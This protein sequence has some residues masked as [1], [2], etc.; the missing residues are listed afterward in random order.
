MG[1][2]A[3]LF[4]VKT[5]SSISNGTLRLRSVTT[6]DEGGVLIN[7]V[8][9]AA[10]VISSNLV[11][12][13]TNLSAPV[14]TLG[15]GLVYVSG[16]YSSGTATISGRIYANGLTKFGAGT[17]LLSG[18]GKDLEGTTNMARSAADRSPAPWH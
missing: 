1:A 16:G 11:F 5:V 15:E 4:G 2:T 17:L 9:A 7:G 12:G 3:S 18:T 10:P 14:P 6:T 8:G 13:N